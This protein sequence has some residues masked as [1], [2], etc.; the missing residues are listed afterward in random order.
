MFDQEEDIIANRRK[1]FFSQLIIGDALRHDQL[2]ESFVICDRKAIAMLAH[3]RHRHDDKVLQLP[4]VQRVDVEQV[5]DAGRVLGLSE[6]PRAQLLT[7]GGV[8]LRMIGGPV[9]IGRIDHGKEEAMRF[10]RP[11]LGQHTTA[12]GAI[13][14]HL[15]HAPTL[16]R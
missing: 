2:N 4:L 16:S 3:R 11:H 9:V 7:A 6:Q 5:A 12:M 15:T 13:A 8:E 10:R 1:V 14:Q